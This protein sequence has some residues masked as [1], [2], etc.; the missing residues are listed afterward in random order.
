MARLLYRKAQH[1]AQVGLGDIQVGTPTPMRTEIQTTPTAGAPDGGG[2]GGG[3]GLG[4]A[5]GA[6]GGLLGMITPFIQEGEQKKAKKK[7]DK[8]YSDQGLMNTE[9]FD[10]HSKKTNKSIN[11]I[12]NQSY[13]NAFGGFKKGGMA[14]SIMYRK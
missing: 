10:K 9:A 6:I 3:I 5:T 4:A 11:T 13:G 1:S 14:G 8:M 7:M 12:N 2:G